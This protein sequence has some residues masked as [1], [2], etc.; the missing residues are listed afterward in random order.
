MP[1]H[2]RGQGF[3]S[4]CAHRFPEMACHFMPRFRGTVSLMTTTGNDRGTP[5]QLV[6]RKIAAPGSLAVSPD[7]RRAVQYAIDCEQSNARLQAVID[8]EII[9][10]ARDEVELRI[11]TPNVPV[12]V[13]MLATPTRPQAVESLIRDY[14]LGSWP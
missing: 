7:M 9:Q 1:S 2:G 6:G 10:S 14:S 13:G 12:G 11:K 4:L 5:L 3:E 8:P